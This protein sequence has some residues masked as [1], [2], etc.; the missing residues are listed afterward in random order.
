MAREEELKNVPADKVE[1]KMQDYKDAGCTD[2][3]STKQSDGKFTI[4][5]TCDDNES[6]NAG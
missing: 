3:K 2:V 5:A 6:D 1:Q 4:T